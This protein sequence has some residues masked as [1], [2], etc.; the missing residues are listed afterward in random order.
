MFESDVQGAHEAIPYTEQTIQRHVHSLL[1][2]VVMGREA[3]SVCTPSDILHLR[4]GIRMLAG[5]LTK[6]PQVWK[7]SW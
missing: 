1:K 4:N 5:S 6:E 7:V 3:P 2:P